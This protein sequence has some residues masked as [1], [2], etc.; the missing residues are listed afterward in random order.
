MNKKEQ[1]LEE[2]CRYIPSAAQT[3]S[4]YPGQY[5]IGVSPVVIT[6][7]RGAYVWDRE[8]NRYL[9]TV[10]ALGPMIFGYANERID[11]AVKEQIDRGT[12]YSLPS[13]HELTLAKLLKESVP[14]A[15]MSRFLMSGNE[16]TSGAVR[17]ARHVTGRDHIAKC[18]YHGFQDWSI[19]TKEGRN[20]GVP[21]ILQTLTHDFVYNDPG[22]LEKLF[23]SY[24]DQIAA[25]ILEPTSSEKPRDGFLEKVREIAHRYGAV[26]IFDEMVT[27]FRWALGGAQEYFGVVPDLACFGKAISGGYPIAVIA[28]KKEYMERM[29]EVFVSTTF[30]GFT[31]G[32]VAAI[33]TITMMREL[34]TVHQY[35]HT[36]GEYFIGEGNRIAQEFKAPIEFSGYGPHPVV[37]VT[38][39][40]DY[41]NR[42]IKTFIYQEMNKAGILFS[43]SILV[44]Y[45]HQREEIDW[46]LS[47]LEKIVKKMQAVGDYKKLE[48]LLEGKIVAPRSVRTTP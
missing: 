6:R 5:V 17:L 35:M 16:A 25:V 18:G 20:T 1:Y 12:I 38:V 29:D 45:I 26:L 22:S 48:T 37:K 10:L 40:D 13:E 11:K 31:L 32:L 43:S 27:G 42:V 46:I 34:K 19:C 8:G 36:L 7:G 44:G 30:G 4:K 2:V 39:A 21:K 23:L 24:P 28:G 41:L 9:D 47:E 3:L 15:E 14:C 33:E